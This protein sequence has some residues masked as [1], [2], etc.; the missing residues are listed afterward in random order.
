MNE[1]FFAKGYSD[2]RKLISYLRALLVREKK[3]ERLFCQF[4]KELVTLRHFFSKKKNE[5]Y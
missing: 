4:S 1:F 5:N 2:V 3:F